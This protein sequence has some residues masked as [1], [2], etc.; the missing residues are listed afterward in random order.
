MN[1]QWRGGS[2]AFAGR[3]QDVE[4]IYGSSDGGEVRQL[5]E[6]LRRAI[7][8]RRGNGSMRRMAS[9]HLSEFDDFLE[10]VFEADG[11]VIYEFI[12]DGGGASATADDGRSPNR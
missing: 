9:R 1:S 7:R 11:V 8:V 12:A 10:A 3:E 2:A 6:R 4:R 5:L